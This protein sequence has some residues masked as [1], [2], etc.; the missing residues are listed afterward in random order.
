MSIYESIMVSFFVFAI[1]CFVLITLS[2]VLKVQSY[3]INYFIKS[4]RRLEE[5]LK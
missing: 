4:S 2:G 1:V 5:K 3:L